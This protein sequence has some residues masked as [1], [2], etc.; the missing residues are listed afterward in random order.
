MTLPD[1]R[2]LPLPR[3][4]RRAFT[5]LEVLAAAAVTGVA[6][7]AIAPLW[8]GQVRLLAETRRERLGLEELA[9]QAERLA[10]VPVGAVDRY[11]AGLDVSADFR[12]F[13]P[14]AVLTATRAGSSPLGERVVLTL[15][16]ESPGRRT[17]PL[18]LVT[19]IRPEPDQE[20][21]R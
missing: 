5:M 10:A 8:V 14:G 4:G 21:T 17:R 11:L 16:W 3:P 15:A 9:N 7:G 12:T 19:W 13:L 2:G 18:A 20:A 6:I 1:S